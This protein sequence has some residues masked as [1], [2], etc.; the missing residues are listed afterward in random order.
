MMMKP[1]IHAH[2]VIRDE[3]KYIKPTLLSVCEHV[4]KILVIDNG[5]TDDTISII[6]SLNLPN[7]M[8]WDL[9]VK[10]EHGAAVTLMRNAELFMSICSGAD[11]MMILDGHEV[12]PERDIKRI[13]GEIIPSGQYDAIATGY[14]HI[15][16]PRMVCKTNTFDIQWPHDPNGGGW[17]IGRFYN[18][19]TIPGIQWNW[20]RSFPHD[21]L[22]DG[23]GDEIIPKYRYHVAGDCRF[24]HF[25]YG[26]SRNDDQY[27]RRQK[28]PVDGTPISVPYP[29]ACEGVL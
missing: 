20:E 29:V 6:K 17:R 9:A 22:V 28:G 24:F 18:L 16:G 2:V 21:S 1:K 14:Y 15:I 25:N 4:D 27:V 23:S 3:E 5:S 7:L 12:W 8:I 11:W 10:R 13:V 26:K 19:K